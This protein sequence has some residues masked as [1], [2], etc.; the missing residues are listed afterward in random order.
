MLML[1]GAGLKVHEIT[2]CKT[3]EEYQQMA[4]SSVYIS[5]HPDA[6][7]GGVAPDV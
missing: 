6:A 5:Y 4:E 7:P 1:N 3:Y 2:S